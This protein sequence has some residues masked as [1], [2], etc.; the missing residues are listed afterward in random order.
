MNIE[1][2]NAADR[3]WCVNQ[4]GG[5]FEHSPWIIRE[6]MNSRPFLSKDDLFQTIKAIVLSA[7]AQQKE[8]LILAHPRLGGAGKLTGASDREQQQAGLRRME[9]AEAAD[10]AA[11]NAA[12]ERRFAFPFIIAV[13]GRSRQEIDRA[14]RKRLNNS[15][16]NEFDTAIRE[17]VRI[18][19][20]RFD[21]LME[22]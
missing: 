18:A 9:N 22:S 16:Q 11:L 4:L 12:Y 2:L 5:I 13:R 1:T 17:I 20:F 21:D 19:R 14:I 3:E 8:Q 7:T 10:L 15:R 6:A